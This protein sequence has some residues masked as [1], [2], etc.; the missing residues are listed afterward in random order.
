[1]KEIDKIEDINKEYINELL[2]DLA[3]N[4]PIFH[5]E[6]DFQF[7]LAQKIKEYIKN[8]NIVV[9]LEYFIGE[10]KN[11]KNRIYIDIMII[12]KDCGEKSNAI[13]I[14]LKYKTKKSEGK[15]LKEKFALK[16]QGAVDWGCYYIHKDLKRIENLVYGNIENK[17][18]KYNLDNIDVK[19]GFVIFLTNDD[20]YEKKR[21][22]IF[23]YYSLNTN[24][25]DNKKVIK[26]K[27]E[28]LYGD[29]DKSNEENKY[30][31]EDLEGKYLEDGGNLKEYK[32]VKGKK[33]I[34][35]SRTHIGEWSNYSNL[36]E[37]DTEKMDDIVD[38]LVFEVERN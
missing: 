37:Y 20:S 28:I 31:L 38:K 8:E 1:M 30:R 5:N 34:T 2:K 29:K 16:D 22:G 36:K 9:R 17:E 26:Q 23:R 6:Q 15:C 13:A 7:E 12:Q 25:E 35:L 33:T 14:E 19:K 4:R 18:E 27:G 3:K 24:M 11:I 32:S 10:K 21:E